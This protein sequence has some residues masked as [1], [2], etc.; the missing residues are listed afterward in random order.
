ML[1]TRF[2]Q[3]ETRKSGKIAKISAP[4]W[5]KYTKGGKRLFRDDHPPPK[6]LCMADKGWSTRVPINVPHVFRSPPTYVQT[7][8]CICVFVCVCSTHVCMRAC[9]RACVCA[10]ARGCACTF[11]QDFLKRFRSLLMREKYCSTMIFER[12]TIFGLIIDLS[13][14]SRLS[15]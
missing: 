4:R 7:N 6:T 13:R 8:V 2:F 3:V 5:L 11:V 15:H 12:D 10:C 9:V 14:L 1:Q